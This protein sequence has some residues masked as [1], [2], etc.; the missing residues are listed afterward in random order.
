MYDKQVRRLK[1]E[2]SWTGLL[3]DRL[4]I[5]VIFLKQGGLSFCFGIVIAAF[6]LYRPRLQRGLPSSFYNLLKVTLFGNVYFC[7][8]K[9]SLSH[10]CIDLNISNHAPSELS[11]MTYLSSDSSRDTSVRTAFSTSILDSWPLDICIRTDS[12]FYKSSN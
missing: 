5:I 3:C 10:H 9:K 2:T 12:S 11:I 8:V 7:I 1:L 6:F 4:S